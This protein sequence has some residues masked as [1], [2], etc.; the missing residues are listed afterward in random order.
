MIIEGFKKDNQ[1]VSIP[2]YYWL[3]AY[4]K[5]MKKLKNQFVSI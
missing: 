1:Y 2:K 4:Q 5:N 3:E